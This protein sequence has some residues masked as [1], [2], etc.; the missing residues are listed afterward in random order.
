M[1]I[2]WRFAF[3]V[4]WQVVC[5]PKPPKL[6]LKIVQ[7]MLQYRCSCLQCNTNAAVYCSMLNN[8]KLH[9]SNGLKVPFKLL[10]NYIS[11]FN[12]S[13]RSLSWFD[14]FHWQWL[15]CRKYI[16]N[17]ANIRTIAGVYDGTFLSKVCLMK[18]YWFSIIFEEYNRTFSCRIVYL[19]AED[20]PDERNLR[21]SVFLTSYKNENLFIM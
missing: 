19:S 20:S 6:Q 18:L 12:Y 16:K 17:R 11:A 4:T 7:T 10:W 1:C 15:I 13:A 5:I 2:Y 14:L 8:I 3:A 21:S 9:T